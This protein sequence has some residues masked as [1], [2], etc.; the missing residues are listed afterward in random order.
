MYTASVDPATR[1]KVATQ[2]DIITAARMVFESYAPYIPIMGKIPPT[3]FV[4][5]KQ[6]IENN[7]L[8]LIESCNEIAG[9][10]VLTSCDDHVLLQSMC[11][12]PSC[13]GKGF[14]RLI[15]GFADFY[16][17]SVGKL[18]IK[19]YT[20]SLMERNQSIYRKAGYTETH[21]EPYDW[22]IR[23]YM[24]KNLLLNKKLRSRN[25]RFQYLFDAL[26]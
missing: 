24:E 21:R 16:T 19:L 15:L 6:H 1:F 3:I 18:K 9:M 10:V 2:S 4:D 20:N 11:V 14:G 5:F 26:N 17:K 8:W 13:Q 7:N 12:L 25:S 23:V 22:G